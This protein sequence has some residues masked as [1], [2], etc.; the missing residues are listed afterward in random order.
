MSG[1]MT[2]FD[3]LADDVEIADTDTLFRPNGGRRCPACRKRLHAFGGRL[4][5]VNPHCTAVT[6]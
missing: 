5:C 2:I 4:V 1:Q 6:R 3:L